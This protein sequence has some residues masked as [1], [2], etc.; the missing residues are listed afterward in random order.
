[1]IPQPPDQSNG[2]FSVG[3]PARLAFPGAPSMFIAR[4]TVFTL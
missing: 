3:D 4:F 2:D 1:M